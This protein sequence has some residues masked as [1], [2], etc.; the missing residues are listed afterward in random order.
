MKNI[1]ALQMVGSRGRV[2]I[3]RKMRVA[4]G[5]DFAVKVIHVTHNEV[6]LKQA[7]K[8]EYLENVHNPENDI[9]GGIRV[10]TKIFPGTFIELK[11]DKKNSCIHLYIK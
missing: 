6:I 11:T 5:L 2:T 7:K 8:K 3:S 4:A 1:V 9:F 10:S